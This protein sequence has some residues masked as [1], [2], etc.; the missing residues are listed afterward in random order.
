[1]T[2]EQ[3]LRYDIGRLMVEYKEKYD[4]LKAFKTD[5]NPSFIRCL[6][7]RVDDLHNTY[8]DGAWEDPRIWMRHQKLECCCDVTAFLAPSLSA[9]IKALNKFLKAYEK[10]KIVS[11]TLSDIYKKV[12]ECC[13]NE[14]KEKIN[15]TTL[16]EEIK[17]F[18]HTSF[19]KAFEK[20]FTKMKQSITLYDIYVNNDILYNRRCIEID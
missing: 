7:A 14:N 1:M 15:I 13:E 16:R 11:I 2:P 19:S 6:L 8:T 20:A 9:F 17:V 5:F 3:L 4:K 18:F 10:A 12:C